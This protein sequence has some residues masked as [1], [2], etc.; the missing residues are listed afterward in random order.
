MQ[1]DVDFGCEG[2]GLVL[3]PGFDVTAVYCAG[4]CEAALLVC[5]ACERKP[6]TVRCS[7]CLPAWRAKQEAKEEE[8]LAK[9]D[10][11]ILSKMRILP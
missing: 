8:W 4:G 11:E 10:A 5:S 9:L 3:D 7:A 1:S 6:W 2:C